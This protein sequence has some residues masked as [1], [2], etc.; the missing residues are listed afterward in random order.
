VNAAIYARK[1]N[2][3]TGVAEDQRS[4]T[5]QIEGARAFIVG[6]G[7]TLAERHVY[8]DENVSGALFIGRPEFQRMMRDADA[9]EFSAVVLFDLDRFGRHAHKTMVALNVL[10]DV[11]VTVWDFSAGAPVDLDS[12]EGRLSATLRAEFAQQYREQV[13]K[14]TRDSLRRKAEAG[15]V[16]GGRVFGY[17]NQRV[18]PGQTVRIINE[19]EAKVVRDI[20][21][22]AA[23]GDGARTI[24]AALNSLGAPSPRAQQGRPS[25]W[26]SSTIRE[27]LRRDLYRGEIVYGRTRSAYGRE[28]GKLS[29]GRVREKAQIPAPEE[30]WTKLEAKES[31]R[32]IDP[33]LAAQVDAKRQDRR[34]RY[35]SSLSRNGTSH[36]PEKTHGKYLL[37]GGMLICPTCG[38]HFEATLYPDKAYICATRRRKPGTC[39]NTLRL[40]MQTADDVVLDMIEGEV[41]GERYINELLTLVGKAEWDDTTRLMADRARIAGEVENLI[42]SIASGVAPETIAPAIRAREAE[43]ARLDIRL[44]SPQRRAPDVERLREALTLRAAEWRHTLRSEP[45]LA[46]LLL[47]RLVEPLTLYDESKRPEWVR[48][49]TP[50]KPALLDGLIHQVASP[51]GTS[52]T[53]QGDGPRLGGWLTAA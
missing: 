1:S 5:R 16:T 4:V 36:H 10:A 34:S 3:Q 31:L 27:V 23:R 52:T 18:G 24:A 7:W 46:R 25:G 51:T 38:G 53:G 6:K 8:Q 39:T 17:D 29:G 20:Y 40:P 21:L 15:L 37:T 14:H 35:L 19:A 43:I 28:I 11:G 45:K 50:P 9:G 12:F 13:R 42:R 30:T 49:E 41:L 44:R 26:S 2:D 22:R 47:R 48:A 33:D 32:I